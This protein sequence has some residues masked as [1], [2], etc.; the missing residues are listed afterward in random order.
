MDMSTK[1]GLAV[2][3]LVFCFIAFRVLRHRI[4][5]GSPFK[6]ETIGRSERK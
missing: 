1:V 4:S 3:G 5:G 2:A 6:K